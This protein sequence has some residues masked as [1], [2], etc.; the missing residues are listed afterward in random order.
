M[1]KDLK[2]D[3]FGKNFQLGLLKALATNVKFSAQ[4]ISD[5]KIEFFEEKIHRNLFNIIKD[6]V[7]KYERELNLTHLLEQIDEL[8]ERRG[9]DLELINLLAG[10]ARKVFEVDASNEKYISDSL[11]DFC[12]LQ[13]MKNAIKRSI[14]ILVDPEDKDYKNFGKISKEID[15]ALLVGNGENMG[16]T[17]DDLVNIQELYRSQYNPDQ[18]VTTG[19][20]TMDLCLKGGMAPGEVHVI[21]GPPKTGK[22]SYLVSVGA[23]ALL[24]KKT[25]FHVSLEIKAHE[26]LAKYAA[27]LT[28]Y[29]MDEILDRNNPNY[30]TSLQKFHSLDPKLYVQY[31]TECSVDCLTIRSWISR[32]RAAHGAKPDLIILD[33]DDCL[34]AINKAGK[35]SNSG[36]D[37]Y[38]EAGEIYNDVKALAD[39][40]ACPVLMA[41]QPNRPAWNKFSSTGECIDS[42]DLANSAKKAMKATSISSLNFDKDNQSGILYM[43]IVRRGVGNKKIGIKRLLDK[44][45]FTEDNLALKTAEKDNG[46]DD[47]ES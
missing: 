41:A 46:E 25:V 22:S 36:M 8:G 4:F 26:V 29:T 47:E 3:V 17:F 35:R 14:H 21:M 33:Y 15:Q 27:R 30:K 20:A 6:Y 42:Q 16:Y 5:V 45:S 43:D 24:H 39:Y 28:P 34:C 9:F 23:A 11:L 13:S 10:E 12:R 37:S 32:I 19:I 40:F 44:S 7:N 31:Y 1:S 2:H 18:L 38:H